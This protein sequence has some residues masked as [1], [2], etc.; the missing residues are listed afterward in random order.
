MPDLAGHRT[1]PIENSTMGD[2]RASDTSTDGDA[3][4]GVG[5]HGGAELVLG[6]RERLGIVDDADRQRDG[7]GDGVCDG[8]VAPSSGQVWQVAGDSGHHVDLAGYAN[9]NPRDMDIRILS[10][11][12]ASAFDHALD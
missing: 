7:V 12:R 1:Q 11:K 10:Q 3:E 5:S 6:K 4:R 9:A 2:E 8:N